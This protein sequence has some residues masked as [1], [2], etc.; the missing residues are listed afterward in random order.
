MKRREGE[1]EEES[2]S[3][4]VVLYGQ[5]STSSGSH[6]VPM[7]DASSPSLYS[8]PTPLPKKKMFVLMCVVMSEGLAGSLLLPFIAFMVRSFG[9]T[10]DDRDIGYYAGYVTSAFFLGQFSSNFLWGWISD[11]KGRRPV[12]LVG[13][14]G[15]AITTLLFGTSQNLAWAMAS[16]FLN[17]ALNGVASVTKS[18]IAEITDESNQALGFS[19]RAAAFGLG[20]ILGPLLGGGLARPY[21]RFP[22]LADSIFG[23]DGFPFLLPCLVS[24]SMNMV[25]LVFGFF[26]LTETLQRRKSAQVVNE[27][28]SLSLLEKADTKEE[29]ENEEGQENGEEKGQEELERWEESVDEG[30]E[31]SEKRTRGG[32]TPHKL[33][34]IFRK[35]RRKRWNNKQSEGDEVS[36]IPLT[37]LSSAAKRRMEEN[38]TDDRLEEGEEEANEMT[39][40]DE[41]KSADL[42]MLQHSSD[43]EKL[44]TFFDILKDKWVMVLSLLYAL[45]AMVDLAF[46][47]VFS[48]WSLNSPHD[49]HAPGLGFDTLQIGLPSTTAAV[50]MVLFQLFIYPP[51][52]KRLGSLRTYRLCI[53]C[54]VPFLACF[55]LLHRL[56]GVSSHDWLLWAALL[57]FYTLLRLLVIG[58]YASINILVSNAAGRARLG[59]ANGV[60]TAMAAFA[61][62]L[63]PSFGGTIFAFSL[64]GSTFPFNYNFIFLCF[65]LL[66]GINCGCTFWVPSSVNQRR[67]N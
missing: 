63:A 58:C 57:P 38:E 67:T 19:L 66:N 23:E 47:E 5:G 41:G 50:A 15:N 48:V 8:K 9:I 45:I 60:S 53:G 28:D 20:G 55:P 59:M 31:S 37:T 64:R 39:N 4:E 61:R 2:A 65:A 18:Y 35:Q 16:R 17:G 27:A 13:L 46:V 62:M 3:E 12:L 14:A 11:R 36:L 22:W 24:F 21:K 26:F 29:L 49:E 42:H 7:M 34:N 43:D 40:D 33:L 25:G 1:E 6:E 10:D 54:S 44:P 56:S 30:G 52:D 51:M 32:S